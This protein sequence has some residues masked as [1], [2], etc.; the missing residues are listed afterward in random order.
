MSL[1]QLELHEAPLWIFYLCMALGLCLHVL[2]KVDAW[3]KPAFANNRGIRFFDYFKEYPVRSI[4]SIIS[5]LLVGL[6]MWDAG[7]K[8]A[9]AAAAAGYMNNSILDGFL[10]ARTPK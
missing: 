9:S 6:I 10:G 5:T 4:I 1:S 2:L 8:D 7:F 3:Y